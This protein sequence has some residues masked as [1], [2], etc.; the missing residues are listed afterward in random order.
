M[1]TNISNV[2]SNRIKN[3]SWMTPKT[4]KKSLEK[5]TNISY[6]IGYPKKWIS[7]QKLI[8]DSKNHLLKQYL[9]L[10]LI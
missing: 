10:V 5:L 3:L 8:I 9:I 2:F 7:Y 4:K 6:K 1:I